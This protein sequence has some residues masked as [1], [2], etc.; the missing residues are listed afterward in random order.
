MGRNRSLHLR[1]EIPPGEFPSQCLFD[2]P[3]RLGDRTGLSARH[4]LPCGQLD[5]G[6]SDRG[7]R[8]QLAG[9][10]VLCG[11]SLSLRLSPGR[12]CGVDQLWARIARMVSFAGQQ[13]HPLCWLSRGRSDVVAGRIHH[14]SKCGRGRYLAGNWTGGRKHRRPLD[15]GDRHCAGTSRHRDR[16]HVVRGFVGGSIGSNDHQVLGQNHRSVGV[17]ALSHKGDR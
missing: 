2:V 17:R 13:K 10:G 7:V 11:S 5:V 6:V 15:P 12:Q 9:V 14:L 16:F 4:L 3:P 1:P 8:V